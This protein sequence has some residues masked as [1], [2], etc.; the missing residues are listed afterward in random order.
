MVAVW[1]S[2]SSSLGLCWVCMVPWTHSG[3]QLG[4]YRVLKKVF[5]VAASREG[6]ISK[7]WKLSVAKAR[8][9]F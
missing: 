9:L 8:L 6:D 7:A 3:V 4:L 5:W 2:R 1:I